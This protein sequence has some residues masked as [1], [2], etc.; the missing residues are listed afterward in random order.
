MIKMKRFENRDEWLNNRNNGIGGSEV[1]SIIGWNPYLTN[2]ELF[3]IKTG[4]RD[5]VDLSDNPYVTYG[6]K[7]ED[8]LRELFKLDFP[9]YKIGYVENNSWQNDKYPWA[10]ASL[11]GWL[12][13]QDGRIGVLEIKTT[14]IINS[15]TWA[16]WNNRVPQNYYC[17]M[18][19]YI[20]V[21]E[22]D[23]GILKAQIKSGTGQELSQQIRHYFF[24]RKDVEEDIQFLMKKGDEFWHYV[25]KNNAPPLVLPEF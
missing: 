1:S 19:F 7:A 21:L 13:D 12:T 25:K 3:E 5:P 6:I 23:F 8:Y 14:R 16:R 2:V 20:A 18:L 15:A 11:D 9:E 4:R 22:A 24:E 10:I 17:Q